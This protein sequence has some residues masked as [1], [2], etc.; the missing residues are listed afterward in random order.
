MFDEKDFNSWTEK[1]VT[2]KYEAEVEEPAPPPA[3]P[4]APPPVEVAPPP[5]PVVLKEKPEEAPPPPPVEEEIIKKT[6]TTTTKIVEPPMDHHHHQDLAVVV[7]SKHRHSDA[8][9]R[10]EIALLERERRLLQMERDGDWEI[11]DRRPRERDVYRVEKDRKGRM[12]LV[13][14]A[15]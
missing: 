8:D 10:R 6:T 4:P 7:P 11:V 1:A 5:P 12:A 15:H 3:E 9:I 14:S 13:R 2:Y